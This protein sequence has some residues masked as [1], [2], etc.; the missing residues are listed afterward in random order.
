MT[1]KEPIDRRA[2]TTTAQL[3][4]IIEKKIDEV[5]E[6]VTPLPPAVNTNSNLTVITTLIAALTPVLVAIVALFGQG[7]LNDIQSNQQEIK[8]HVDGRLSETISLVESLQAQVEA[9][10]GPK[11]PDTRKEVRTDKLE[12][13]LETKLE[14][15]P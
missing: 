1:T 5:K 3:L 13:E 2:D 15:E 14:K 9:L 4:P 8:V 6:V 10:G 12:R 11:A 7:Q